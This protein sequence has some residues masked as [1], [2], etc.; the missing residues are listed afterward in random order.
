MLLEVY[1][2]I[3]RFR[4]F[5]DLMVVSSQKEIIYASIGGYDSTVKAVIGKAHTNR[6]ES[7]YLFTDKTA[8]GD[9]THVTTVGSY[10][11]Y[12]GKMN[13]L[14]HGIFAHAKCFGT[15]ESVPGGIV[16][17]WDGNLEKGVSSWLAEHHPNP[18]LKEWAPYIMKELVA[19]GLGEYGIIYSSEPS[20]LRVFHIMGGTED[21]EEIIKDGLRKGVIEIPEGNEGNKSLDSCNTVSEYLMSFGSALAKNLSQQFVPR[22]SPGDPLDPRLFQLKRKPFQAQADTIQGLVYALDHERLVLCSSEMG[23]GKTF[24]AIGISHLM[25]VQNI[26]VMSPGHLVK[27]WKREIEM[28]IDAEAIIAENYLDVFRLTNVLKQPSDKKRFIIMSKDTVK[29]GYLRY[30]AVRWNERKRGWICPGC[31]S[32]L[33]N[34]DDVPFDLEGFKKPSLDNQKCG[35]CR[36]S[37]WSADNS[38][39]RK[40]APID[41]IKRQWKNLI[42]LLIVDE[43]HEMKGI[44]SSQSAAF[45]TLVGISKRT[46]GLTGTLF[47]GFPADV[48]RAL[49]FANPREFK[50]RGFLFNSSFAFSKTYGVVERTYREQTDKKRSSRSGSRSVSEKVLPGISPQVFGDFL[51]EKAAFLEL[52]DVTEDLPDY[53]EHVELIPMNHE[54]YDLYKDF[55]NVMADLI[56]KAQYSNSRSR[57][58]GAYINGLMS[59]ADH[60][61]DFEPITDP[62]NREITVFEPKSLIDTIEYPKEERLMELVWAEKRKN[63]KCLVYVNYT[64]KPAVANRL[65]KV[66]ENNGLKVAYLGDSVTGKKR[67]SWIADKV[68]KGY[69]VVICNPEKVKT[70]LDLLDFPTIIFYETGYNVMTLR[71]AAKRSWRIGQTKEVKVIFMVY[72]RTLQESAIRLIG[73]KVEA[74]L[75]IEG[76]FSD[77]ALRKMGS[78]VGGSLEMEL[79]KALVEGLDNVDS[80]EAIWQRMGYQALSEDEEEVTA[81]MSTTTPIIDSSTTK[82]LAQDSLFGTNYDEH[83]AYKVIEITK[84]SKK[85]AGAKPTTIQMGWDFGVACEG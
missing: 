10:R 19:R 69:D 33:L 51:L 7:Y 41:I 43:I 27:K 63:R 12:T 66:F 25:D 73:A 80:A 9:H 40:V 15:E 55:E 57:F 6:E 31:G 1:N 53:T 65:L 54:Q 26:F 76:H 64:K 68:W 38:T 14:T 71:Q 11:S 75:A 78:G 85:K 39:H 29:L 37:L 49:F 48:Y 58:L 82:T 83:P 79:A 47:G 4:V 56:K 22:H 18:L 52:T 42:D 35:H 72:E 30:P 24:M 32:V 21:I 8:D 20:D 67:E 77:D 36:T 70:G 5:C 23:T 34:K 44:D 16:L 13:D 74:A 81:S 59:Y 84:I 28:T 61:F 60:P 50:K 17:A 46:L 2:E 45:G 3:T 62:Q